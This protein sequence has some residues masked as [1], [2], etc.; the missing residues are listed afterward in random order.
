MLAVYT[1][2]SRPSEPAG[3]ASQAASPAGDA[4]AAASTGAAGDASGWTP[5]HWDTEEDPH[6]TAGVPLRPMDHDIIAALRSGTIARTSV[7]DLFP[8]QPYHVRLAG[9]PVT[10]T[11]AYV[12]IDLNRDDKWDERWDLTK[13]GA[14]TRTVEHDPSAQGEKVVYTLVKGRWQPH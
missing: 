6:W 4:S 12:L 10:Q 7:P 14:I 2:R 8:D 3:G 1:A 13:P 5:P 9:S 11:F